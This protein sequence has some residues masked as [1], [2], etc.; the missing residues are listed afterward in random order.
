[1][2]IALIVSFL[3]GVAIVIARTINARLALA[4]SV[5]K[6]SF[7]N[8]VTGLTVSALIL[9]VM[10][11]WAALGQKVEFSQWW[12]YLGGVVGAF[13]I[14]LSNITVAKIPSFYMT[15]LLFIGQVTAGII[16]DMVL[17]GVLTPG[18]LIGGVLAAAGLAINMW[19]DAKDKGKK[20][21]YYR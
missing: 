18:H 7:Y 4:T 16:L 15:L 21:N 10:G 11:G 6:S 13:I 12:M 14:I 20:T 19:I 1:M 5:V 3:S 8:Y 9:L 17:T 2:L